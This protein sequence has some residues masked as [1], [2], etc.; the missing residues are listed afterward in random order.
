MAN[1]N[2][3]DLMLGNITF[4]DWEVPEEI[5]N[6]FG[7][8]KLAVHDFPGGTRTV[9]NLGNFPFPEISWKGI[10]WDGDKANPVAFD[11]ATALN[12][13]RKEQQPITLKWGQ[14]NYQV[15]VKEFEIT[16]K[17]KQMLEYRIAL[18]PIMDQTS[19]SNGADPPLP[20]TILQQAQNQLLQ[21]T[22]SPASG[23]AIP[24][25]L[26]QKSNSINDQ[27]NT[28]MVAADQT[29]ADIPQTTITSLQN[30][31]LNLQVLLPGY[32]NGT[33]FPLASAVSDMNGAL[34]TVFDALGNPNNIIIRQVTAINPNLIALASE[35]YG[36]ADLWPLIASANNLQDYLP[37]GSFTLVIPSKNTFTPFSTS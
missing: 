35:F 16:G 9:Q 33:D 24:L 2:K 12:Q 4:N 3:Q 15:V 29:L 28:A 20:E 36:D 21:T 13:L 23:A 37:L 32:I 1:Q 31:I 8:N 7:T 22:N 17:L 25:P 30:Q 10:L 18:V 11:R 34:T 26:A 19:S 14:F 27:I 5:P 6:L